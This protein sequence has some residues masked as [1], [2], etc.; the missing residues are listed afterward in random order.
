MTRIKWL[1]VLICD[2][3]TEI[4]HFSAYTRRRAREELTSLRAQCGGK[5]PRGVKARI[6]K[7]VN[8]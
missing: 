5:L 3:G 4:P 2:G 6:R 7:E 1:V 8:S